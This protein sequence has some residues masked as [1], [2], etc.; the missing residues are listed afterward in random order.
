MKNIS[1]YISKYIVLSI[2]IGVFS[3]E[4]SA[5]KTIDIHP[6][7]SDIKID[8]DLSET[9]WQQHL[10]PGNFIQIFPQ[11]GKPSQRKSEIAI[12]YNQS[13]L[14]VAAILY[15]GNKNEINRQ[16]TS[17]DDL[18]NSDFFGLQMDPFGK[19]REGY[20][21]SV[22]AAG[23]QSDE[24][25]SSNN[26]YGNFNVIWDSAVEIYDDKW[27]VEIRIPFNSIRFPKEDLSNFRINFQRFSSKL[28]EESF[29]SPIDPQVDG[30]LN[31]FG[32][33]A[34]LPAIQ[35]PLNLSFYPFVSAVNEKSPDGKN[36][37]S[38][39]GGMD[40]KY[41]HNNAYTL[42]VS[43]IPDFSQAQSDD[44]IFN[45]TPFE[46]KFNENRQFFVEGTELFDKGNYLYT[47]RIG[48][49]PINKNNIN[50][51]EVEEITSN[52][53]SAN[54]LNLVKFTGKSAGGLSIGLL[55][56]ITA[57]SEAEILNTE[58]GESRKQI[59]NPFTNY[60]SLV[61]DQAL[62][63]NSS[64]T[65]I[66]NSVLRNGSFYDANLTALL[67]TLYNKDRTYS[68][69]FKKSISQQYFSSNEKEIS[70]EKDIFGHEYFVYFGKVSGNWTGGVSANLYDENYDPNDFGFLSRN[71]QLTF[72]ADVRYSQNNPK[73]SL[74]RYSHFIDIYRRFYYTLFEK[75]L[76]YYKM[77]TNGTFK[78]NNHTYFVEATYV[79]D[80]TNFFEARTPDQPFKRPAYSETF[81]EYQTNG[82]KK[83]SA[84][85]YM[86]LVNY[87]NS[88]IFDSEFITGYGIRARIGQHLFAYLAQ[89]YEYRKGNAGFLTTTENDII[90][91]QRNINELVN[92][93]QLDYSI[94]SKMSMNVR[95]R[96]YW[97]QVDYNDQFTLQEN[98]DLMD[99]DLEI[100][101]DEF[102]DNF[103]QFNIDFVARWQ[104]APASEI[105]LGYKLGA[106]AFNTNV[107]SSYFENLKDVTSAYNSQTLSLK[108]TYFLDANVLKNWKK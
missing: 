22:T 76:A 10:Q 85:G 55:N 72:R 63:N 51:S 12:L 35:P 8:G 98:G 53:V 26:G 81:L 34:G 68:F 19:A 6:T 93:I 11:N 78:K 23:V 13:F 91:G 21:F 15:V 57:K 59:T 64:V 71:N 83:L 30:Y 80:G 99:N 28:N 45:L 41:V 48:G 36:E 97:I 50:N 29:W 44:Q 25:L 100:S 14:Y 39:N 20:D 89:S 31:Q 24:K 60:N 5:Q 17:R 69:R 38:F 108:M 42:D 92:R 1:F 58:T 27:I 104:F 66:N 102:D 18:G 61:L 75:E 82:N 56:G 79:E 40:V 84:A 90:F 49:E 3:S 88:P 95:L 87:L 9:D 7:T 96:H 46:I 67:G 62:K 107:R 43:L 101:V 52:P 47:R 106:Y 86:V 33:L 32:K 103:N 54:I 105:S 65:F 4:I 2:I 70:E 94:N 77:G 73:K 74:S 16:L 37:T